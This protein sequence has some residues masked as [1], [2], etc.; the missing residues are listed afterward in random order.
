MSSTVPE[1]WLGGIWRKFLDSPLGKWIALL[2][3]DK[4]VPMALYVTALQILALIALTGVLQKSPRLAGHAMDIVEDVFP[5]SALLFERMLDKNPD[6]LVRSVFSPTR[7]DSGYAIGVRLEPQKPS[8]E[9]YFFHLGDKQR[10]FLLYRV[11]KRDDDDQFSGKATVRF[12]GESAGEQL[13]IDRDSE[14]ID[15]TDRVIKPNRQSQSP[16]HYLEFHSEGLKDR[17]FLSVQAV[18]LI[19]NKEMEG[20]SPATGKQ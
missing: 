2:K 5:F 15:V 11:Q 13:S 19:S 7:I 18:V 6:R 4:Y 16:I 10:V 14:K 1:S 17:E 8:S 9:R 3:L 12:D 20:S